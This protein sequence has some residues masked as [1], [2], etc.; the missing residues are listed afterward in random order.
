[1]KSEVFICVIPWY[2]WEH[3]SKTTTWTACTSIWNACC[4]FL[5]GSINGITLFHSWNNRLLYHC[6]RPR[7]LSIIE[8]AK[9]MHTGNF[10]SLISLVPFWS[11]LGPADFACPP[12]SQYF[13]DSLNHNRVNLIS[14]LTSCLVNTNCIKHPHAVGDWSCSG[15]VASQHPDLLCNSF[16]YHTNINISQIVLHSFVHKFNISHVLTSSPIF[17]LP[18]QLAWSIYKQGC[19]GCILDE[20]FIWLW[21]P[22]A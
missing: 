21:Q 8:P 4:A 16:L 1:M 17:L 7:V 9:K 2:K 14:S 6:V 22:K 19:G 15:D 18:F 20:G 10:L 3:D 12:T 11:F 5:T 13:S